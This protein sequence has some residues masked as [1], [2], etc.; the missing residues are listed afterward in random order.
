MNGMREYFWIRSDDDIG[1]VRNGFCGCGPFGTIVGSRSK[2]EKPIYTMVS[3]PRMLVWVIFIVLLMVNSQIMGRVVREK[4]EA[5]EDDQRQLR[6]Y[7]RA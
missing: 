1:I 2:L 5:S 3:D 4:G 7:T 6:T